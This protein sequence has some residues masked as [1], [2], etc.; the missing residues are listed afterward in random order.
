[1]VSNQSFVS[2]SCFSLLHCSAILSQFFLYFL[3]LLYFP[4]SLLRQ[5]ERKQSTQ[6]ERAQRCSVNKIREG[7][8]EKVDRERNSW[9]QEQVIQRERQ[10]QK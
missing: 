6:A 8:K 9:L 2:L 5:Q 1:M 7:V 3:L 4:A 10:T